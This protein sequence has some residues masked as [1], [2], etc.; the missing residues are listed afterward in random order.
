MEETIRIKINKVER[1]NYVMNEILELTNVDFSSIFISVISI[2]I[3]VKASVSLFEWVINKLGLETKWM[4]KKREEHEL[5]LQT[6]QSLADLRN[7]HNHDVEE[8]NT[9]DENIKEELSIF[10]REI[11]SSVVKTQSEIKQFTENRIT[12]RQQS[13]EIQKELKDSI[14]SIVEYNSSKDRQ[15]D[16]LMAAQREVLADKINE[17][18]KYY[19]SIKGIPEDEVDE[20]TNL[21]TAYKGVGGNHSGDAKYEYCMNHLQVIPVKTKLIIN[22]DK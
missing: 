11:K 19:I 17:K 8:S 5:L 4:R 13:L 20:F 9:H 3:G 16:N 18:Y 12:D 15:I 21:H 14:K 7:Q 1:Q 2:L 22:D 6:S 10:M